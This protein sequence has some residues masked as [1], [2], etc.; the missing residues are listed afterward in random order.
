MHPSHP[1][2]S[3]GGGDD[4]DDGGTGTGT[5]TDDAAGGRDFRENYVFDAY[6][7]GYCDD[8]TRALTRRL[9]SAGPGDSASTVRPSKAEARPRPEEEGALLACLEG[10]EEGDGGGGGGGGA[11]EGD[12]GGDRPHR[13]Q[14]WTKSKIAS[15]IPPERVFLFP[16]AVPPP[17]DAGAP[18]GAGD[19]AAAAGRSSLSATAR[20]GDGIARYEE[21][22]HCDG[23]ARRVDDGIVHKCRTCFDYDLCPAC[24][25]ALAGDHHGGAHEFVVEKV[26]SLV[27]PLA[28]ER[29]PSLSTPAAKK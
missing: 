13:R 5:T 2:D 22:A 19:D 3:C 17:D 26:A 16:G 18:V 8:V 1:Q 6:L 24:Y 21:I 25:E 4:D 28:K 23:C 11:G 15:K 12:V 9:F 27:L 10:E 20:S 7:L 14:D 29:M